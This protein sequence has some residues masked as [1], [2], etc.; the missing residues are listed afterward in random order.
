[1][2]EPL[3]IAF[4]G[5]AVG[6]IVISLYMPLFSM[7]ASWLDSTKK[8]WAEYGGSQSLRP[9][10]TTKKLDQAC[11]LCSMS[12]CGSPGWSRFAFLILTFLL[13][14]ELAISRLAPTP[15][16]LRLFINA[17]L[18]WY[19]ISIFYVLL[20]SFWQEYRI[21]A[22]LQVLTDLALVTLVVYATGG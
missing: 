3:L 12:G 6:G 10:V 5:I 16:P 21:Q 8:L 4:L 7:I 1:M 2:L 17:I 18:L 20:L 9:C 19:T 14:I 15:L 22:V 13:G 11:N